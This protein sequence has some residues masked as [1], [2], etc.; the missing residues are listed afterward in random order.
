MSKPAKKIEP[1]YDRYL[2]VL[3]EIDWT[4]VNSAVVKLI[5]SYFKSTDESDRVMQFIAKK[6]AEKKVGLLSKDR[7]CRDFW[8]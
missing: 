8:M 3:S 6:Q 2:P 4:K 1:T 7:K 5:A